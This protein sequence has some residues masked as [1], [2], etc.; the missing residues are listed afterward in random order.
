VNDPAQRKNLVP[1]TQF[2][3][4]LQKKQLPEYAFIVPNMLHDAH[5]ASLGA[6]DRWLQTNIAPLLV[7]PAFQKDGL[8]VIT[9]DEAG[10]DKQHGGGKVATAI[11]SPLAK[12]NYVSHTFFQHP[13]TLRL[14]LQGLGVA[15]R[16]GGAATAPSMG[17]F[18][19]F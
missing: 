17:E 4:D 9:F 1:F 15:Q 3:I 18:F 12:K 14:M 10:K 7:D 5:D 16:P 2:A 13:S 6:A 8:L 19:Q 11:V